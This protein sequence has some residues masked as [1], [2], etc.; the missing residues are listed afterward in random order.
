MIIHRDS[1]VFLA[2]EDQSGDLISSSGN[3]DMEL[4]DEVN[5]ILYRDNFSIEKSDFKEY[6]IYGEGT[7]AYRWVIDFTEIDKTY[8]G[9]YLSAKVIFTKNDKS[10]TDLEDD[11]YLPEALR[12]PNPVPPATVPGAPTNLEVIVGNA[13]VTIYWDAPSSNGGSPII[14]YHIYRATYSG[15]EGSTPSGTVGLN[16]YD[17][18]RSCQSSDLFLYQ[19]AAYNSVGTGKKSVEVSATPDDPNK[20]E[21]GYYLTSMDSIE[22][23]SG[24]TLFPTSRKPLPTCNNS[25]G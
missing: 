19:I 17:E 13:N 6:Q 12:I 24:Y 2:L 9:D 18:F 3:I 11:I 20:C 1:N 16:W 21:Y 15:G 4:L 14:G 22:S 7:I 10:Y 8:N 23:T 5:T 25:F